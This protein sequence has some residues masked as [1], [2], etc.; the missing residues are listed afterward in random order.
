MSR[1]YLKQK[2]KNKKARGEDS[3]VTTP[4]IT[5]GAAIDH[6]HFSAARTL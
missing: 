3:D 6:T 5:G 1:Q 2:N 4:D